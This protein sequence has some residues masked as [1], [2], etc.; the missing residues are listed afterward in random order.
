MHTRR[1]GDFQHDTGYWYCNYYIDQIEVDNLNHIFMDHS[2]VKTRI[3]LETTH[4]A[5]R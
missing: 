3:C 5:C 1:V 2:D 4:A